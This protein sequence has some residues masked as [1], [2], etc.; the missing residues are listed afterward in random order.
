VLDCTSKPFTRHC[1]LEHH[2]ITVHQ[3]EA[4][5]NCD[6]AKCPDKIPFRKNHCHEQYGEYQ[7]EDYLGGASPKYGR[8]KYGHKRPE[9]LEEFR[10]G[11]LHINEPERVA[12]RETGRKSPKN[13][14]A[15]DSTIGVISASSSYMTGCG[16]CQDTWLPHKKDPN[17]WASCPSCWQLSNREKVPLMVQETEWQQFGSIPTLE[18]HGDKTSVKVTSFDCWWQ[19]W[20]RSL[21]PMSFMAGISMVASFVW[22]NQRM[23]LEISS[24]FVQQVC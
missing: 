7:T 2:F 14:P 8:S 18:G 19:F 23:E 21:F 20:Y 1:D 24:D 11:N 6:R 16:Q 4:V 17:I 10:P 15:A 13:A 9:M 5:V 3:G 22:S 12:W